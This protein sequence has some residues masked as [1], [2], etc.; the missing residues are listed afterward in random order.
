MRP[1]FFLG[2]KSQVGV[3]SCLRPG[4]N[5]TALWAAV[6]GGAEVVAA[7]RAQ[8]FQ[9]SPLPSPHEEPMNGRQRE[10][11]TSKPTWN[12]DEPTRFPNMTAYLGTLE[13]EPPKTGD[14]PIPCPSAIWYDVGP[15]GQSS[16]VL[17]CML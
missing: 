6:R 3:A 7:F 12:A 15:T 14:A 9:E 4:R 1:D 16:F 10:A 17:W 5:C 2:L 13:D 11:E 8:T